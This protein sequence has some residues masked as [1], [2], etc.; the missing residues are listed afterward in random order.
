MGTFAR[1]SRL[2]AHP[3]Q[4]SLS[5][6]IIIFTATSTPGPETAQTLMIL[7]AVVDREKG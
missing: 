2:L 6:I 7:M 5:M 4:L 3:E 1:L